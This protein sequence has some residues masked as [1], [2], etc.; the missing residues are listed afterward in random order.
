[1]KN[2]F[3]KPAAALALLLTIL[4]GACDNPVS[5]RP[6]AAMSEGKGLVR[7]ETGAAAARAAVPAV[8]FARY[9]YWFA[10]DG[11]APAQETPAEGVFEL[12]AG[13]YAV[14]VKAFVAAVDAT[15][16]TEG[17]SG[18]FTITA[19][20]DAGLVT[21][22]LTPVIGAGA[23]TLSFNLTFPSE[24]EVTAL[25]LTRVGGEESYDLLAAGTA[26]TGTLAG[27]QA[28]IGAGYWLA[29]ASLEKGGVY[30]GK[31]E[32]AHICGKRGGLRP[33]RPAGSPG[34]GQRGAGGQDLYRPARGGRYYHPGGSPAPGYHK[35]GNRGER[36]DPDSEGV[37]AGSEHPA[38]KLQRRHD[39]NHQAAPLYGGPGI[40]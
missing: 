2:Y 7:V 8:S 22:V 33:R 29:R 31:S 27:T 14:T 36:R 11:G 17:T 15:P 34:Q 23:G 37:C 21:V 26:G 12:E 32:V 20:A 24:A 6:Q 10:K 1:M 38:F 30:V 19:G 5:P 28:G 13:S 4:L 9:E 16:A 39:G 35:P 18:A 40:R 3:F 25:T